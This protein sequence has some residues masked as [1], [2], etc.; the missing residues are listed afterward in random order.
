M[1]SEVDERGRR[2]GAHREWDRWGTRVVSRTYVHGELHG[3]QTDYSPDGATAILC[4]LYDHGKLQFDL[5]QRFCSGQLRAVRG[6]RQDGSRYL[7]GYWIDGS[8]RME[9]LWNANGQVISN[10]AWMPNGQPRDAEDKGLW[11]YTCQQDWEAEDRALTEAQ[12][13]HDLS[14]ALNSY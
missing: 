5:T 2:H 11:H 9:R 3:E 14:M 10:K 6:T 13:D 7:A 1:R 8:K 4:I 12:A